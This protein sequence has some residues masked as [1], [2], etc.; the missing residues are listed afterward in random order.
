MKRFIKH[1]M[2]LQSYF[3][4]QSHITLK[5]YNR[6][7]QQLPQMGLNQ[8]ILDMG[9]MKDDL[10]KAHELNNHIKILEKEFDFVMVEEFFY[11]SLVLLAD[12]LC[13]P[14]EYMVGIQPIRSKVLHIF[15]LMQVI[16][17]DFKKYRLRDN[18]RYSLYYLYY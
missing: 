6:V 15:S 5:S 8:Q 16:V 9:L 13:F 18:Q 2:F 4:L 12:R 7:E 17:N 14:L 10:N 1:A 11:E 3:S